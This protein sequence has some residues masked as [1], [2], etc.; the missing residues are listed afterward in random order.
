M[1]MSVL[2]S[3]LAS[4]LMASLVACSGDKSHSTAA[5]QFD[6]KGI[7]SNAQS[8]NAQKAESLALISEQLFTLT[9]FMH[10]VEM[11]NMALQLDPKN[12]KAQFYKLAA[13]P[14]MN[15]KGMAVR[16]QPM[17]D[18][19]QLTHLHAQVDKIPDSA[20]K[21]FLLNG[22]P[23]IKTEK[24]VQK[25]LDSYITATNDMREFLK[26]NK[27]LEITLN[28]NDWSWSGFVSRKNEECLAEYGV[29]E[30]EIESISCPMKSAGQIKLN[31]AD[32]EA[33]Q[34]YYAGT[35]LLFSFYNSYDLTGMMALSKLP[36]EQQ[37]SMT[38]AQTWKFLSQYKEF[39][40]FRS[41]SQ[42]QKVTQMG[43]D[44][45]TALRWAV[46]AQKSLCKEGVETVKNRPGFLI[47]KGLCV[48]SKN[49]TQDEK[50]LALIELALNGGLIPLSTESTINWRPALL[51]TKPIQ[52]LKKLE[53]TYATCERTTDYGDG[54]LV[55]SFETIISFK[56]PTLN[57]VFP[58]GELNY[59]LK[60]SHDATCAPVDASGS[61]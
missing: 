25:F 30:D 23:D 16:V 15:L 13:A 6:V 39:G 20:L 9:N 44:Y 60:A 46:K 26:K 7:V 32:M 43:L 55:E 61:N 8:T 49:P 5:Q 48:E 18:Q 34:Q 51:F 41:T 47:N 3:A 36:E 52:D 35:Q 54:E 38:S 1:K 50:N 59:I 21:T 42:L 27:T 14:L 24:D 2:K 45:T 4:T 17:M 12:L 10:S 58:Q 29:E 56:D 28:A 31:M 57:G 33:L 53:P 19:E 11:A 40:V 22:Q 37:D